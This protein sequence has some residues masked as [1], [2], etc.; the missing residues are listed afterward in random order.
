MKITNATKAGV[1]AAVNSVFYVFSAFG[2]HTSTAREAAILVAVNVVLGA[3]AYFTRKSSPRWATP[4]LDGLAAGV[5]QVANDIAA[6]KKAEPDLAAA[7]AAAKQPAVKKP[8]TK[9]KLN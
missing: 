5:T 4:G 7:V 8:T 3:V 2:V 1:I 9:D 6:I